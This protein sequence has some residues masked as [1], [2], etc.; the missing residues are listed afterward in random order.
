VS[1]VLNRVESFMR[2]QEMI[3]PGEC[4]L[5]AVS[6]GLDSM[7]LLELLASL[8]GRLEFELTA[9]NFDHGLRGAMGEDERALVEAACRRLGSRVYIR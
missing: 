8:R 5:A 1:L 3:V 7:A 9:A 2:S 6:G 4:V